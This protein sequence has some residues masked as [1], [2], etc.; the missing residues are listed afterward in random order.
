MKY[1]Y[2]KDD[3]TLLIKVGKVPD[4]DFDVMLRTQDNGTPYRA[5]RVNGT[6]NSCEVCEDAIKVVCDSHRLLPGK[7]IATINWHQPDNAYSD[8]V[9]NLEQRI[10]T[11][12]EL[13]SVPV[14]VSD[15]EVEAI[16]PY[17]KGDKGEPF[18][19][20]DFTEEEIEGLQKPAVEAAERADEAT[21]AAVAAAALAST[22]TQNANEATSKA[23]SATQSAK[24]AT[25][26]TETATANANI[27]V[28]NA[29]RA[30]SDVQ[31]ATEEALDA[32][33]TARETNKAATDAESVRA[34]NEQSR[35]AD[36]KARVN[37]ETARVTAE[38]GRVS[39]EDTRKA[40]E[41]SRQTAE[42]GRVTAETE[43]V[44]AESARQTAFAT[45]KY[46][47]ESATQAA[48]TAASN[49]QKVTDGYADEL[50]SKQGKL[51]VS[52]DLALSDTNLL[53]LTEM[54]KKRLFI[55]LWKKRGGRVSG[56]NFTLN[57]LT[58]TYEEA[59]EVYQAS[60][61]AWLYDGICTNV[62]TLFAIDQNQSGYYDG[63][64]WTIKFAHC[65][66]LEVL[67]VV[68][69][70][71]MNID[72]AFRNC[73]NLRAIMGALY[74]TKC[75]NTTH[76]TFEQCVSLETLEIKELHMNLN[77][78]DSPLISLHSLQFILAYAKNTTAIVITVHP[79]VYAK[80]TDTANT[81]WHKVLTDAAA[82]NISF[83][84]V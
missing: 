4:W 84:T 26:E 28:A 58:L 64:R 1:I 65:T 38:N 36:E 19:Y 41:S 16:M 66:K 44:K 12:V 73:T 50:D 33:K 53:S 11:G 77:I 62:R 43:R 39:A 10:E 6:C 51:S 63:I 29:D 34:A 37:A 7:I 21:R 76:G 3:F 68:H 5:S 15:A 55:D 45:A 31:S 81:E 32:A 80:L 61:I 35:I 59:I 8:G 60:T 20:G 23:D 14:Q 71:P 69:S 48:N 56:N 42:S 9:K 79:D 54:A 18:T 75:N 27:A 72:W 57:G 78:S 46:N 2:Y 82:K 22:A 13:T 47:A 74:L 40:N 17:I 83:A 70:W 49:A 67:N 24:T 52:E 30:T 25:A